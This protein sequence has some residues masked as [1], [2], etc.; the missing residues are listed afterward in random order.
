MNISDVR[1]VVLSDGVTG[2]GTG[3]FWNCENLAGVEIPATVTEIGKHAFSGCSSLRSIDLPDGVTRLDDYT[4]SYCSSLSR[5]SLPKQLTYIGQ[6]AF[7]NCSQLAIIEIPAEVTFIEG[8]AF[9]ECYALSRIIM[10]PAAPPRCSSSLSDGVT[11][12]VPA[13]AVEDYEA[14]EWAEEC[15]VTYAK[16]AGDGWV[17]TADGDLTVDAGYAWKGTAAGECAEDWKDLAADV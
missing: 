9:A 5:V 3:A 8:S 12:I 11:F 16:A 7:T 14:Q 13:E 2:I 10:R 15:V 4:F 17:L 6:Y 1:S